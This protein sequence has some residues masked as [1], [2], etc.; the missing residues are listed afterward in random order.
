[1]L[2][3]ADCE[4]EPASITVFLDEHRIEMSNA[5]TNQWGPVE[6]H[7]KGFFHSTIC[8]EDILGAPPAFFLKMNFT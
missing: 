7:Y 3:F 1:M 8:D 6:F 4:E 5:S 2:I